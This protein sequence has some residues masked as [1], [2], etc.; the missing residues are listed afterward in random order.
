[1]ASAE[2]AFGDR[3]RRQRTGGTEIPALVPFRLALLA[4]LGPGSEHMVEARGAEVVAYGW[5]DVAGSEAKVLFSA[6]DTIN[7]I[8][9]DVGEQGAIVRVA[10]VDE[11]GQ[12]TVAKIAKGEPA[13]PDEL[14]VAAV[15]TW[16]NSESSWGVAFGTG[17]AA[18]LIAVSANSHDIALVRLDD[19]DGSG[20]TLEARLVGHHH[21]VPCVAFSES[22]SLYSA[23]IDGSWRRWEDDGEANWLEAAAVALPPFD[24]GGE[25]WAWAV[26]PL[27]HGAERVGEPR[28][29]LELLEHG[30]YV[31]AAQLAPIS[32]AIGLAPAPQ[33]AALEAIIEHGHKVQRTGVDPV[34]HALASSDDGDDDDDPPS[35]IAY[36]RMAQAM[37][38]D[39]IAWEEYTASPAL[40]AQRVVRS[41]VEESPRQ[42]VAVAGRLLYV[43]DEAGGSARLLDTCDVFP[44]EPLA[45]SI[46]AMARL[47]FLRYL[48]GLGLLVVASQGHMCL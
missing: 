48:S 42:L 40:M 45:P 44:W 37:L 28:S 18:G 10:A 7:A 22:G 1:M 38:P 17:P 29:R 33:R 24:I 13:R 19:G 41:G 21:N 11:A 43:Y 30:A 15:H 39:G 3:L 2:T 20:L 12:L 16:L 35:M 9:V 36:E 4:R 5:P 32:Q 25:Q 31:L 23:S 27:P 46:S 6:R 26:L 34:L 8:A 47:T 14:V